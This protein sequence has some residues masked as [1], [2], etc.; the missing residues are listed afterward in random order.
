MARRVAGITW[1]DANVKPSP[2]LQE[3]YRKLGFSSRVWLLT[4][5]QY[6]P[7][8]RYCLL[9]ETQGAAALYA[10]SKWTTQAHVRI[11]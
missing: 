1:V 5:Q 9:R 8:P 11:T 7:S 2:K 4:C 3:R 10:I 6:G